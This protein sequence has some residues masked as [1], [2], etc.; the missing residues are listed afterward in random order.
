MGVLDPA[1][2]KNGAHTGTVLVNMNERIPVRIL[3]PPTQELNMPADTHLGK[4]V[5]A[6]TELSNSH[7]PPS[8]VECSQQG[9]GHLEKLMEN[10]TK[11]CSEEETWEIKTLLLNYQ[12][13]FAKN[14]S[15][16]GCFSKISHQIVTGDASH[17]CQ[18][19]RQ[20]PLELQGEAE[21]HLQSLLDNGVVVPSTSDWVLVR[22]KDG[23]VR[24]CIDYRKP[25]K[26]R[27]HFLIL[28]NVWTPLLALPSFQL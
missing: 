28:K 3:N 4:L 18:L 5:E 10:T 22:K 12:D 2:L 15:D 13:V 21:Q 17:V 25:G 1:S 20:K 26:T 14:A 19:V 11:G 6:E 27:I 7:V 8:D 23:G 24:W 16:V 9:Q